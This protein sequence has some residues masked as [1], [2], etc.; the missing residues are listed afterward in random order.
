MSS[1]LS[2][3][4]ENDMVVYELLRK[5][6]DNKL[7]ILNSHLQQ[8][9]N[10]T[11]VYEDTHETLYDDAILY[12]VLCNMYKILS[13]GHGSAKTLGPYSVEHAQ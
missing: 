7:L 3:T 5:T 13:A 9:G 8:I 12:V 2:L 11:Q 1:S 6:Y 4:N 10:N